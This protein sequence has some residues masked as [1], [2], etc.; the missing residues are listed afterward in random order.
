VDDNGP[1]DPGP[2]NPF[3]SDPAED[4]SKYHPFDR[5]Q[6]GIDATSDGDT[7]IV[8]AGKYGENVDLL[9]KSITV[10]SSNP[11]DPSIVASTIIN[12][13]ANGPVV[14]MKSGEDQDCIISGLTLANGTG[15]DVEF[16]GITTSAGGGVFCVDS[17]PV[18]MY[19]QI[20]SNSAELGG[21]LYLSNSDAAIQNCI[22]RQNEAIAYHGGGM[23]MRGSSQP[24]LTYC[25]VTNNNSLSSGGG[26]AIQQGA[27]PGITKSRICFNKAKSGGGI[28]VANSLNT[29]LTNCMVYENISFGASG[30]G[31]YDGGGAMTLWGAPVTCTNCV[32]YGNTAAVEGGA[33]QCAYTTSGAEYINSIFWGNTAPS[34]ANIFIRY[35]QGSTIA[36]SKLTVSYCDVEDQLASIVVEAG[37]ILNYGPDNFGKDP[38]FA[39]AAGGDFHLQSRYGRWNESIPAW[40]YDTSTSAPIDAGDP[41]DDWTTELW[42]NGHRINCGAYGGMA[43]ASM[44]SN[45][46]G[47]IADFNVDG[48]V[49]TIDLRIFVTSHLVDDQLIPENLDRLNRVNIADFAIFADNWLWSAF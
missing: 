7:V 12:G 44:S 41:A 17:D 3:I 42:P 20:V 21:G 34:G 19:C 8:L 10:R 30:S 1:G 40:V 6:E 2:Y 39:D 46:V 31:L 15:T 36:A 29:R 24:E 43:Q 11:L 4:G 37:C 49:D 16:A 27:S 28:Y 14:T 47:N 38:L 25:L 35:R 13:R 23:Y 33:V 5:V 32:F 45:M 22:I 26:I 18:I 9:G 48:S